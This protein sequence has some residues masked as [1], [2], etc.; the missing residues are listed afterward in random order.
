M[1]RSTRTLSLAA[2]LSVVCASQVLAN[3]LNLNGCGSK[4]IGMGGAFIGLADDA[5]AVFW[6]PGGLTQLERPTLFGYEANL[7][8]TGTYKFD[9]YK[10]DAQTQSKVYPAGAFGF[11]RPVGKKL[12]VGAEIYAPAGTGAKWDGNDL[13][14]LTSNVA[15]E[16][17]SYNNIITFAPTVAYKLT[18]RVS[19]GAS[20]NVSHGT[21]QLKRPGVGQ[22]EEDLTGWIV[23]GT[24]GLHVRP[25]EK[26]SVGFAV[27]TPSNLKLKGDA[28]MG[29][30]AAYKL[31]DKS[32]AEREATWPLWVGGGIAVKP[33][34]KL[35]FTA[36]A[37]LTNWKKIQTIDITYGD[38]TWQAT[39]K[40]PLLGRGFE[41]SFILNWK[42]ATQL[43]AGV[44]YALN[45]TW[46][47]RAGYY[48][49]P[50][51]SPAETLNVLLPE[52]TYH[53]PTAGLGYKGKRLS[54]DVCVEA[55][56]GTDAETPITG[57]MPGVHGMKVIVP[58][59]SISY[60]F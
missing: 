23:G 11:L 28:T 13:K 46:A 6:N 20:F 15:Y 59:L 53:V 60:G 32:T 22:Y 9:A 45:K 7:F 8:P 19:I 41:N 4:A 5:S 39:R 36:D 49:D 38:A 50:S 43:R 31:P 17:E 57:K 30:A 52:S 40:H 34:A 48:Y 47:L 29:G 10:I 26:V 55:L 27:R 51:P 24:V 21:L 12:V 25:S 14:P 35:T 56:F 2:L 3:G 54:V 16:W 44:E 18:T 37:Q 42:N 1:M 33:T 58:T